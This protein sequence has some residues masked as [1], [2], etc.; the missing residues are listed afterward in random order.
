MSLGKRKKI[1]DKYYLHKDELLGKGS[2]SV[3]YAGTGLDQEMKVAIKCI[4]KDSI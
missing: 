1:G 3:V 2:F 4:E